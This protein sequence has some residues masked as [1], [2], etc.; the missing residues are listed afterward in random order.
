MG[1]ALAPLL[2]GMVL[3]VVIADV[4]QVGLVFNGK[5]LQPNLGRSTRSRAS[6]GCSARAASPCRRRSTLVKLL[7]VALR[8]VLGRSTT[9]CRRS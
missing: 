4:L 2:V 9:G 1:L 5:R 6:A 3:I 7:L 8:R